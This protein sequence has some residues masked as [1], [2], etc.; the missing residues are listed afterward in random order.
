MA[1]ATPWAVLF[2]VNMEPVVFSQSSCWYNENFR[3]FKK[4]REQVPRAYQS[5][6]MGIWQK[7][8]TTFVIVCR[9]LEN[10]VDDMEV[11]EEFDLR[12]HKPLAF[13]VVLVKCHKQSEFA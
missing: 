8:G 2:D 9:G 7:Q 13:K 6:K 11:V 1:N 5:R 12:P 10:K 4:H 3:T